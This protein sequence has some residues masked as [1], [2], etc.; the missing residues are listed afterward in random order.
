[1]AKR[2]G[3]YMVLRLVAYKI[4]RDVLDKLFKGVEISPLDPWEHYDYSAM[5]DAWSKHFHAWQAQ[6]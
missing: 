4:C 3:M 2:Y 5:D 1:M 6:N